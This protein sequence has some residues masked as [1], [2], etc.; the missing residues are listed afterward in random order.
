MVQR[1][2]I[3]SLLIFSTLLH[4]ATSF[5]SSKPCTKSLAHISWNK[6]HRHQPSRIKVDDAHHFLLKAKRDNN[7]VDEVST[8]DNEPLDQSPRYT[9][10]DRIQ[11]GNYLDVLAIA[12]VAFFLATTWLS[13]GR[14]FNNF[15]NSDSSLGDGKSRV[16]KYVDADRV[17]QED[18][19]REDSAVMF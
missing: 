6:Q 4:N 18:F 8:D 15:T 17:L 11:R 10:N 16:Y 19:E 7:F 14:L 13:G 2:S 5:A 12:V 3:I 9:I 1:I